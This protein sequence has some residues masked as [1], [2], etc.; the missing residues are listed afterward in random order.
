MAFQ[1]Q[2][3]PRGG[4]NAGGFSMCPT[5]QVRHLDFIPPNRDS[6]RG[7]RAQQTGHD[8]HQRHQHQRRGVSAETRP[9]VAFVLGGFSHSDHSHRL[10]EEKATDYTKTLPQI[11]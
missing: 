4:N 5:D 3:Q 11:A 10:H 7:Q 1:F 9:Q 2:I 8:Q 6:H